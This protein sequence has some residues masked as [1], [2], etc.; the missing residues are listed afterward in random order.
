VTDYRL[1]LA[2]RLLRAF[3]FGFSAVLLGVHLERRGLTPTAIGLALTLALATATMSGLGLAAASRRLGRR[4]TLALCGCLMALSGLD[5]ASPAPGWLLALS[6]LTGML[7]AGADQG[8]FAAVE[9]AMLS[10]ATGPERRNRAFARYSLTGGA[11][12]AGGAALATLGASEPAISALFGLYAVIGLATA[13]LPLGMSQRVEA[14]LGAR[15]FGSLRPLLA[16]AALFAVD[17]FGGGFIVPSVVSYW[18]HVRFGAGSDVLGPAFTAMA[19]LQAASYEL[20]GRLADRI[21]LV[22]TMVLTHLPS[23]VLLLFV[24]F[25]PS[26]PWALALLIA[27]FSISQMDVPAR[28]AYIV[29]IVK[30]GERAG[31]VALTGAVR[32]LAQAFGP[33]LAGLAIQAAAF[34]LPFLA[35]GA[36]KIGYDVGLYAGFRRR[37]AEHEAPKR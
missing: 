28:Q 2:T 17:S 25:S 3:G 15:V 8:P 29:S 5:L 10:E 34:G 27:R 23:N 7:G 4:R 33:L 12:T 21:G 26:L 31:A 11:A 6:G 37:A 36:I 18:L 19:L 9:Q 32:G 35:G 20:S 1:L 30:P 22:N 16:L 24:A 14:E 13:L